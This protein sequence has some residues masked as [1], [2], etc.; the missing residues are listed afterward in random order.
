MEELRSLI[1]SP[2]KNL[3][4]ERYKTQIAAG[5]VVGVRRKRTRSGETMAF[6]A[7]DDKTARLEVVIGPKLFNEVKDLLQEDA[8][9]MVEG[10][11]AEDSFNGG[12]KVDAKS[13]KSL[14]QARMERARGLKLWM[15]SS[16]V[17]EERLHQLRTLLETYHHEEGVPV[18]VEY[19]NDQVKG[20]LKL[21]PQYQVFP[22]DSLLESIAG[23]KFALEIVY[24]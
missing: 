11:V 22:E 6:I 23:Q 9:L 15:C 19:E 20:Q 13:I 7:L 21:G 2:L 10:E 8:V 18:I 3:K 14:T 1:G 12:I 16:E 4:P 17:D 24:P 5:L